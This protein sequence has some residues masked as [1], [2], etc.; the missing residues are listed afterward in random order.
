MYYTK[1]ASQLL[2]II[3]IAMIHQ[4]FTFGHE[5][6]PSYY[7]NQANSIIYQFH[8]NYKDKDKIIQLKSTAIDMV[9]DI[10][11]EISDNELKLNSEQKEEYKDALK[12]VSDISNALRVITTMDMCEEKSS[13]Y[14]GANLL[15]LSITAY[16]CGKYCVD[17][18]KVTY[19]D[20]I[21]CIAVNNSTTS[22]E[23]VCKWNAYKGVHNINVEGSVFSHSVRRVYEYWDSPS[24]NTM[25]IAGFPCKQLP[26]YK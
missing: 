21:C 12:Y 10:K 22:Y 3:L 16:S 11:K 6:E 20:L 5:K 1:S 4:E 25:Y 9:Y 13:F 7:T 23:Y 14:R 2:V 17:I 26:N 19:K 24:L 18:F 15:G 8:D